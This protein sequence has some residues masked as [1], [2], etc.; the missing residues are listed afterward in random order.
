MSAR[1]LYSLIKRAVSLGAAARN[2]DANG[3]TVDTQGYRS[4]TMEIDMGVGGITFDGTNKI[5]LI[6]QHSDDGSAWSAVAA[7]D[8][9]GPEGVTGAGIVKSFIAAHAAAACYKVGYFGQKRYVRAVAD[10]SGTHGTATPFSASF[11]LG[12]PMVAPVA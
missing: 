4:V 1:D 9:R 2:A 11:L 7:A 3:A 12:D 10:F 6:L 5:E 8:A